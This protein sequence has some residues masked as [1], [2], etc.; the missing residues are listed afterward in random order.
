MKVLFILIFFCLGQVQACEFR[1]I[2]SPLVPSEILG[3][4]PTNCFS[5]DVSGSLLINNDATGD[6]QN[7]SRRDS[8][9][10]CIR[11]EGEK[12]DF[13]PEQS[14]LDRFQVRAASKLRG[15][16]DNSIDVLANRMAV[17]NGDMFVEN[18]EAGQTCRQ[19]LEND[20]QNLTCPGDNTILPAEYIQKTASTFYSTAKNRAGSLIEDKTESCGDNDVGMSFSEILDIRS[21]ASPM[22]AQI[23][24]RIIQSAPSEVRNS[25]QNFQELMQDPMF[26]I[27]LSSNPELMNSYNSFQMTLKQHPVM[28]ELLHNPELYNAM[29]SDEAIEV[30]SFSQSINRVF[31]ER[32]IGHCENLKAQITRLFC[33]Q[34]NTSFTPPDFS[35]FKTIISSMIPENSGV[36]LENI[37]YFKHKSISEQFCN[38]NGSEYGEI[39]SETYSYFPTYGAQE[40]LDTYSAEGDATRSLNEDKALLCPYLPPPAEKWEALEARIAECNPELSEGQ[41]ASPMSYECIMLETLYGKLL[42]GRNILKEQ[43]RVELLSSN[44]ELTESEV[45]IQVE[46]RLSHLKAGEFLRAGEQMR[47]YDYFIGADEQPTTPSALTAT[48]ETPTPTDGGGEPATGGRA[49]V[50]SR[51]SG[52]SGTGGAP[53]GRTAG[54]EPGSFNSGGPEENAAFNSSPSSAGTD[55][56]A[57][58]ERQRRTQDL[59][60]RVRDRLERSDA[61]ITETDPVRRRQR[62]L[63]SLTPGVTI[64]DRVST[65]SDDVLA[66][67][68]SFNSPINGRT[69]DPT[70]LDNT[71][72]DLTRDEQMNAALNEINEQREAARR[73]ASSRPSPIG[74][75]GFG[76][77]TLATEIPELL[78]SG[79]FDQDLEAALTSDPEDAQELLD[80]LES[81]PKTI[82]ITHKD[83]PQYQVQITREGDRYIIKKL[84]NEA[85][86][87]YQEF[88]ASIE[89]ALGINQREEN[90]GN[91]FSGI[92]N[93]L[94][95]YLGQIEI[96]SEPTTGSA[97]SDLNLD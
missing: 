83:N 89:R 47:V 49:S 70:W 87:A 22:V 48:S 73:P 64:P 62:R 53:G 42:P 91:P 58:A 29:K 68:N 96:E 55:S 3:L 67:N 28:R 21:S 13:A 72:R 79:A 18:K 40:T 7:I 97:Y 31:T 10:N 2:N 14:D 50:S 12:F 15:K 85:E 65:S 36:T 80:L 38:S 30:D 93:R 11:E 81:N 1:D 6:N 23:L 32:T 51:S 17:M 77:N 84:G 61:A 34:N 92:I 60:D 27:S 90:T 39:E 82:T 24:Q 57:E 66:A 5:S 52:G 33:T 26:V 25:K 35:E 86:G 75:S 4:N 16:I 20:L 8:Y 74:I 44:E 95:S 71:T 56:A 43:L 46:S 94:R 37:N 9:C 59:F 41:V 78:T 69:E 63:E 76:N 19:L 54:F 45:E 88:V